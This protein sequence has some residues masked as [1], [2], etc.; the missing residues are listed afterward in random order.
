MPIDLKASLEAQLQA[1][2]SDINRLRV[3]IAI[4]DDEPKAAKPKPSTRGPVAKSDVR[5]ATV[6][7]GKIVAAIKNQPGMTTTTLAKQLGGDQSHILDALKEQEG[8]QVPRGRAPRNPLVRGL[9]IR[10][11]CLPRRSQPTTMCIREPRFVAER[12]PGA[13][14]AKTTQAGAAGAGERQLGWPTPQSI[15]E[16]LTRVCVARGHR[17]S[18]RGQEH[19]RRDARGWL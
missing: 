3:A 11:L 16:R 12:A 9:G 19:R 17:P 7:L 4:L 5:K 13:C 14:D 10:R 1:A 18:W 2:E 8:K 15:G 6:P